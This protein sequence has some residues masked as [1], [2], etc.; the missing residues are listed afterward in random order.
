M[1]CWQFFPRIQIAGNNML[2]AQVSK[3]LTANPTV[4]ISDL[5]EP[6]EKLVKREGSINLIKHL[7]PPNHVSWKSAMP[8]EWLCKHRQLFQDYL[9][10]ATNSVLS[11]K[12]HKQ[13]LEKLDMQYGLIQGRKSRE[14]GVDYLDDIIRMGLSQLHQ[15]R[16]LPERRLVAFRRCD[17]D[18]QKHLDN[19]LNMIDLGMPECTD[20]AL[21]HQHPGEEPKSQ[22]F[23]M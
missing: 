5:M 19:L 14:D 3:R 1:L 11:G 17:A 2:S 6:V 9:A 8:V 15:C 22:K 12:K 7:Q 18:M 23:F 20:L 13:A 4:G 10:V 21:Q 16:Q